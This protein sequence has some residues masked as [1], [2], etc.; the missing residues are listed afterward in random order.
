MSWTVKELE[1]YLEDNCEKLFVGYGSPSDGIRYMKP[2]EA[3]EIPGFG[4]LELVESDGGH[5]GDGE[6]M[7]VVFK[8]GE[9]YFR[10]DGS[11]DS[12]NGGEWDGEVEEVEP[13]Q[14]TVT[15][16]FAKGEK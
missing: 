8:V 9:R 14:I 7:D 3:K 4:T 13:R 12:W 1:Q 2:N 10:Q 15:R 6:Y 16:Y 11:Y 5:E